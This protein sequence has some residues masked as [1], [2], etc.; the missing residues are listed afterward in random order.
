MTRQILSAAG[1]AAIRPELI[2]A[3][4]KTGRVV[5]ESNQCLLTDEELQ[6]GR[7]PSRNTSPSSTSSKGGN[8]NRTCGG[9]VVRPI[10]ATIAR[11]V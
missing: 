11:S 3:M 2:Y 7:T 9:T 4:K 1:K 10:F 5:T 8:N 6:E